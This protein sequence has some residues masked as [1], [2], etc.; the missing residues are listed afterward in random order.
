MILILL[1]LTEHFH[2]ACLCSDSVV[3]C[4]ASTGVHFWVFVRNWF[5]RSWAWS[6]TE[7]IAL[8]SLMPRD[9]WGSLCV[10]CYLRLIKD[11]Q[12]NLILISVLHNSFPSA[13]PAIFYWVLFD[14][15]CTVDISRLYLDWV[16][17]CYLWLWAQPRLNWAS[18]DWG[19]VNTTRRLGPD[20][21]TS[22][23]SPAPGSGGCLQFL[24]SKLRTWC[25]LSFTGTEETW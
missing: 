6:L 11:Q 22:L 10:I 7:W 17:S 24:R 1:S 18:T 8:M 12:F 23:K 9:L 19:R 21:S 4:T 25:Q 14:F 2:W 5:S 20:S 13:N 3:V 15:V 16:L